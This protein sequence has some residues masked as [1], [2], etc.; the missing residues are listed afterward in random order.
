MEIPTGLVADT[1]DHAIDILAT[2]FVNDAFQRYLV[3]DHLNIQDD[4]DFNVSVNR[5]AFEEFMPMI[6]EGGETAL[7][8]VPG[9]AITSIWYVVIFCFDIGI[10]MIWVHRSLED[11]PE[12][13]KEDSEHVPR[14]LAGLEHE[15]T[16]ARK[17][18]LSAPCKILHLLLVANDRASVEVGKEKVPSI[19]N[20]M[21]PMLAMAKE[22]G[23]AV[24]L[25]ATTARSRDVYK[26]LGFE[27]IGELCVG[28]GH[29]DSDGRRLEGGPGIPMWVMV[30]L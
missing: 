22:K 4:R 12:N 19:G 16:Q 28:K 29:A 17:R 24:C 5:R 23:W 27:V 15:A 20:V 2:C 3:C 25:E 9:S 11:L 26:Y 8:T 14:V 13:D 7:V 1:Q 10:L 21:R 6:T 18:V 30:C